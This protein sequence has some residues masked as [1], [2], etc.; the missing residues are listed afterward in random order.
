MLNTIS[1]KQNPSDDFRFLTRRPDVFGAILVA[2]L[3]SG[4][5]PYPVTPLLLL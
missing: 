2:V 5:L 3:L 1:W 4:I